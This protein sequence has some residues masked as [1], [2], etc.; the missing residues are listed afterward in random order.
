MKYQKQSH[1]LHPGIYIKN[2][3]IPKNLKV[4]KLAKMLGI[5]RPALSNFLNGKSSLSQEMAMQIGKA[6]N[7]DSKELLGLQADFDRYKM[8]EH[9][10]EIAV[11]TYTHSVL[12]IRASHIE[13]WSEKIEARSHFAVL[14]RHL[15]HST[16][17]N[18]SLV[19]FPAHENSQNPGWETS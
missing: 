8:C 6:F 3:V 17:E 11:R 7:I 2:F 15:V 5:G 16:G 1:P 19:D 4:I 12:D 13:A 9:E 18:L 10:K 14:L